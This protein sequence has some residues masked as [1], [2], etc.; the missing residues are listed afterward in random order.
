MTPVDGATGFGKFIE[1]VK[2]LPAWLFSALAVAAGILLFVPAANIELPKLTKVAKSMR[3]TQHKG[4]GLS[5]YLF[6]EVKAL[7]RRSGT[8]LSCGVRVNFFLDHLLTFVSC[9]SSQ[10]LFE[11]ASFRVQ[12]VDGFNSYDSTNDF[13]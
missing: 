4:R 6:R 11:E 12:F 3:K 5:V 9:N 13:V 2:D 7:C 10:S 8:V 1:A